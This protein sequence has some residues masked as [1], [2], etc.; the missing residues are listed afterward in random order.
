MPSPDFEAWV[1]AVNRTLSVL[2]GQHGGPN[3]LR[4]PL[5]RAVPGVPEPLSGL[6]EVCDGLSWPEVHVGYFLDPAERVASAA[7]RG[8]PGLVSGTRS[9]PVQVFGSDG[10][11][12][13][14]A[15]GTADGAV[16]LLPSGGA[17]I[18]SA[19]LE[20]RT[21]AVRLV[22]PNVLEFLQRLKGDLDAFT[23]QTP[24][25]VYLDRP[26]GA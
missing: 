9:F 25:H 3:E 5:G 23:F 11:G 20:T 14:F 12:A 16:Y 24:G 10:G 2:A 6:Y 26:R 4:A 7:S 21:S 19:F 22:G 18:D 17:V 1:V 8:E 15:L 13:R